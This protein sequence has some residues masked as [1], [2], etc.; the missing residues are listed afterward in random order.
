MYVLT[1]YN[2]IA[3]LECKEVEQPCNGHEQAGD[4]KMELGALVNH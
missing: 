1:N 3:S 2:D 4:G